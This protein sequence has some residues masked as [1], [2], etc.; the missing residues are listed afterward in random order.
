MRKVA[1]STCSCGLASG[2]RKRKKAWWRTR[3]RS[4]QKAPPWRS[5]TSR[6]VR[7][8]VSWPTFIG[9]ISQLITVSVLIAWPDHMRSSWA[10]PG[11]PAA[12]AR[13]SCTKRTSNSS[14]RRPVRYTSACSIEKLSTLS[15]RALSTSTVEAGRPVTT[16]MR[17]SAAFTRS[18]P[19]MSSSGQRVLR[20][21]AEP[22]SSAP[23][24]WLSVRVSSRMTP[25]KRS[26]MA[27]SRSG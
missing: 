24:R 15:H 16:S 21:S 8:V 20:L 22:A 25:R 18:A 3:S 19:S 9:S 5:T 13:R 12:G 17:R 7:R 14:A 1:A 2:S 26:R 11:L 6:T 27:G 23:M 10:L 4:N